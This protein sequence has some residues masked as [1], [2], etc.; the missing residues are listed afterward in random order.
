MNRQNICK[1]ETIVIEEASQN[2][3]LFKAR[4]TTCQAEM[5]I[6]LIKE[7]LYT[8]YYENQT[9]LLNTLFEKINDDDYEFT[10]GI[11]GNISRILP[12]E[13]RE[14]KLCKTMKK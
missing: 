14:K 1:H 3:T 12:Q 5:E 11:N 10:W 9:F 13:Q 8:L 6:R 4:C 7:N 2:E